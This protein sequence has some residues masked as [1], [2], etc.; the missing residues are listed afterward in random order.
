MQANEVAKTAY[1]TANGFNHH[2]DPKA[3]LQELF[4]EPDDEDR[5][6]VSFMTRVLKSLPDNLF[7]HEFGGGPTL[8]SVAALAPKAREIHFSDVVDASLREV[9][10]W[11]KNDLQAHDWNPYI[12]LALEADGLPATPEAIAQ[13]AARMRQTIT[14]LMRCDG[15]SS[16]PIELRDVEYDLVTA[17]HCT[18]VAAT[19]FDEWVQVIQ[20]IT[21]IVRPGGWLMLSV[22]TGAQTY[23]VGDV[24]FA[25]VNLSPE[26]IREGLQFAGYQLDSLVI[27]TYQVEHA[28][29]Y[30][31]III[32]MARRA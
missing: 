30:S 4:S 12:K 8:Y 5:Y 26:E 15:Q 18:D 25:C 19:T 3:Y 2:F 14:R 13:R 16:D 10:L 9:D 20:N 11:L 24:T 23:Q 27:D 22:T 21:G 7:I 17:H 1:P 28:Q 31:G 6:S 29:E 32:S